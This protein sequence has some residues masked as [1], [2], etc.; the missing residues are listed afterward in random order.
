MRS[1]HRGVF[2]DGARAHLAPEEWQANQF[3]IDLLLDASILRAEFV[4]RFSQ[5]V[6]ARCLP[7]WRLHARTLREHSRRLANSELN[8]HAPLASVF[9]LSG[10]AMAIALEQRGYAVEEAPLF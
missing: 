5:S 9:G 8:G 10:E 7:G 6:I 1:L 3:A 2:P 4:L